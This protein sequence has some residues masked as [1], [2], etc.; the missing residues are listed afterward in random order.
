MG[1]GQCRKM[2]GKPSDFQCEVARFDVKP[3]PP[4]CEDCGHTDN[5]SSPACLGDKPCRKEGAVVQKINGFATCV[6]VINDRPPYYHYGDHACEPFHMAVYR[7]GDNG[8]RVMACIACGDP[9]AVC[10]GHKSDDPGACKPINNAP[11]KC[12]PIVNPPDDPNWWKNVT[13]CDP[14]GL[15][16]DLDVTHGMC[17]SVKCGEEGEP[18]CPTSYDDQEPIYDWSCKNENLSCREPDPSLNYLR[19]CR[20]AGH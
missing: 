6:S 2:C 3:L 16:C 14:E 15:L 13:S 4:A 20:A 8:K 5:H 10:C 17:P 11:T 18:C 12:G 9:G 1:D 7:T 19:V